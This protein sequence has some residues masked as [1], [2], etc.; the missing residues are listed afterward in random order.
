[1]K[2]IV[3]ILIIF[4]PLNV[5][6]LEQP[7]LN[8][9]KFIIYD[10]TTKEVLSESQAY[11]KTSIASLTK[12]MTTIT[13]IEKIN[14]LEDSIIITSGMINSVYWNASRAGLKVGDKVTYKD[15]LYASILPSGADATHALAYSLNGNLSSYIDDM[16][17]LANKLELKNTKF[18]SV[19]GLDNINNY[20]TLYDVAKILEYALENET[21]KEAYTTKEYNLTNG[22]KVEA[23]II[24][25]NKRMNLDI[26]RIVG[27]KTGYTNNA[28]YCLSSLINSNN[29]EVIII[30]GGAKKEDN[31]YYHIIDT[32]N[33]IDY[34]DKL[35]AEKEEQLRLEQESITRMEAQEKLRQEELIRIEKNQIYVNKALIIGSV[36][37]FC[38]LLILICNKKKRKKRK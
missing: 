14:N 33:L 7:E 31:N 38:L 5:Y 20:S 13:A 1:M 4:L 8:S 36:F 25:F 37:I 28:G 17:S 19:S 30:T 9:N 23:T 24:G 12:I 10:L 21:F 15:L 11:E 2:K 22:L 27:S 18:G 6:A 16:N 34:T 26:S 35:I 29:H 3:L 32:L